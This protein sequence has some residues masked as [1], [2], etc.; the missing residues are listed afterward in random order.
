[1]TRRTVLAG[2][3]G[4]AALGA[5]GGLIE[6]D[7]LPGRT[8]LHRLLGLTGPDG[9]IP[10]VEPGPIVTG[11]LESRHVAAPASWRIAY[12][13]RANVG[14][15]LPVVVVLHYAGSSAAGVFARLGL[16]QF[17]A[18]SGAQMALAAVD[19]G[20]RGYWQERPDGTDPGQMVL[21]DFLPML[22]RR[23]LAADEPSWLGWSMGGYGVLRL[24]ALR[25]DSGLENGAVLAVSPALWPSFDETAPGAFTG[26]D[27]YAAAMALLDREGLPR[28]RI[29]CGTSD[30]FYRNVE[31]FV[32]QRSIES[33]FQ[34][35]DHTPGYWTRVLPAEL[36][37]LV[38][39]L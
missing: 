13:P 29:D 31:S 26:Q 35:G 23:G 33:D 1:M 28:A 18:A 3:V 9:T 19:G 30:P 34:R 36:A 25:Q 27:Q 20:E 17:L 7:V 21:D 6:Y 2:A 39:Q 4:A 15:S 14:S 11:R 22:A 32:D 38:A 16:P 5:T 12:P 10:E 24:A 37:W 8:R